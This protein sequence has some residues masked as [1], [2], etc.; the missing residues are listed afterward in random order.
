M[1][2]FAIVGC[3][4]MANAHA[5]QLLKLGEVRIVAV[6]D[7]SPP[8]AEMFRK[9]HAPD[10]VIYESLQTLI[11]K[12]P[13]SGEVDAIVVVTPH[14]LHFSQA[15]LALEHGIHVLVE[16]PMVTSSADALELWKLSRVTQTH[17]AIAFQSPY[18]AAFAYLA[19]ARG[20]GDLGQVQSVQGW[21]SQGWKALCANT[22]RLDPALSG[23]GFLYDSGSHLL[24]A[25][26]WLMDEPVVEVA[27]FVDNLGCPVEISGV[28]S[29]RFQ[30]GATASLTF[31]GNSPTFANKLT[32]FSD[33][34]SIHTDAYGHK[35]E[36]FDKDGK[37][38]EI[39]TDQGLTDTPQANFVAALAGREPLR[40][41][42]RYGLMLCLLMDAIY[43]S[44]Q[45]GKIV[46]VKPV[47]IEP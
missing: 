27:S 1:F 37:P 32:L 15:K 33:Q 10:A 30:S 9:T 12:P 18:T 11:D 35:L 28:V 7:P 47:P 3:G 29:L 43:E 39:K 36:I 24:N 31:A 22:W 19:G 20:R 46:K 42:P 14:T 13:G 44:A 2:N 8:H 23:G 38:W 16:K 45:S 4:S 5:A 17:L 6:V 21:I 40:A 41:G 34:C 25:L 26:I